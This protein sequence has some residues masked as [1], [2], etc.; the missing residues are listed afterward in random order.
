MRLDVFDAIAL[1]IHANSDEIA[2]KTTIQK[3]IY[4][5]TVTIKDLDI[6][7]YIHYFYGP[8]NQEVSVALED[9][10][11]FS[12]IDQNI[13]SRY[14]EIYNYRLTK[15]GIK[16]AETIIEK[17]SSEFNTIS[18]TIKICKEYCELKPTPLSYAA[19][20]HHILVNSKDQLEEKYSTKDVKKIV[21][22]FDWNI[23]KKDALAGLVLLQNLNLVSVS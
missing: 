13:I 16:Y 15:K 6:S 12:Y 3:L 23:S 14:Y 9:M 18:K 7:N 2:S 4:F 11:E 1:T 10:S 20:A 19:K 21:K 22:D 5:H 8:Y 17:Y